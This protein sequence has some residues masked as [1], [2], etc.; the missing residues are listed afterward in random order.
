MQSDRLYQLLPTVYRLRDRAQG[1]P[2][3]ALLSV[4]E[5]ELQILEDDI[6]SLYNNWFIETCDEWVVPYIG[7]LLGVRGLIPLE[8]STFSQRAMV[9]NTLA[10]RRRKGTASVLEQLARD[11][12][13][14]PAKAVEFF[15]RLSTHQYLNHVR[16]NN[17]VTLDLRQNNFLE[18]VNG[19]FES[20]LHTIDVRHIDNRRGQYNIPNIGLFL[21]RLQSYFISDTEA[22]STSFTG[23]YT[24][25]SLGISTTLFNRPRTET[26]VTQLATEANVTI[27]LRRRPLF[28][29]LAAL[30]QSQADSRNRIYFSDQ[31]VFRVFTAGHEIPLKQMF[32][33]DLEVTDSSGNWYRPL[34]AQT[35][36]SAA[37]VSTLPAAIRDL[38]VGV[39]PTLGRIVM[40]HKVSPTQVVPYTEKVEV[41]YAY[42]FP[43]DLGGGPY[44]RRASVATWYEPQ[45]QI[46]DWQIGVTQDEIERNKTPEQLVATLTTAIER[47]N[48]YSHANPNT[49]GLIVLMDNHLYNLATTGVGVPNIR[50]PAGSRLAIVAA[51]WI[52]VDVPEDALRKQRI[53]GSL[54]PSR[55][56]AHVLGDLTVHGTASADALNPGQL[57]LDGVLLEGTFTVNPGNLEELNI[58]HSTLLNGLI[59]TAQPTAG[60]QNERLSISLTRSIVQ[61][62]TLAAT[63]PA[64]QVK[65]SLLEA[66]KSS[67]V[68]IT[69]PGA[70]TDI[71]TSTILGTVQVRSIEA[72]NSIFTQT[73]TSILR[74]TGCVRFSYVPLGSLVPRRFHCHPIDADTAQRIVPQFTS[75]TYGQPNYGQ[76]APDCPIEILAGAEDEGEMGAFHF[77]QQTQRMKNFQTRLTEYLPFGLE[78]G[79]FLRN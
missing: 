65:D 25:N 40:A 50:L 79:I 48:T 7:D 10:Y 37:E 19:P 76:L 12:T 1:D 55:K 60:E 51:D 8:G 28:D 63:V 32:I 15:Q 53:A 47:W 27:P 58:S 44:N 67:G 68:A 62:V 77:L 75:L 74:Q 24:F 73:V 39:D 78:A 52:A 6:D 21:W 45:K 33:C 70:T 18:L 30:R 46:V 72:S 31:P 71:E 38:R 41:S 16:S 26:E 2:L 17:L 29:E 69:A 54:V 56:R 66:D 4:L 59:A 36:Q 11:V 35:G 34:P 9:A 43:G 5:S 3:R 22:R 23:C 20:A 42:G 13:G 49:F 64:L 57:I 61:S 14:W